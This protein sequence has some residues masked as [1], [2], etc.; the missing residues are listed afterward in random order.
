[1]EG[2][3]TRKTLV[4]E[5]REICQFPPPFSRRATPYAQSKFSPSTVNLAARS[6]SSLASKLAKM[7]VLGDVG[8]GKTCIVNR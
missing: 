5:N 3:G 7:I 6:R 1:M 4:P 2:G 8:V